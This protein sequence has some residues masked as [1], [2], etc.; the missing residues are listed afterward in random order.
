[1]STDL[2]VCLLLPSHW[3]AVTGGAEMQAALL[4]NRLSKLGRFDVHYVARRSAPDYVPEGY[5]LHRLKAR[6]MVAGTLVLELPELLRVLK[7]LQPDVIYQRVACA[8]TGAAAW[9]ARTQHRR[10]VWHV[11]S[12]RDLTP[13]PWKLSWR[14]PLEQ[15]SKLMVAYGARCA[16]TVIVQNAAQA[17]FL[18]RYHGR[19]DAVHIPNFH[20]APAFPVK[21]VAQR[22]TVC[23]VS[24]VKELKQPE[25]FLRLAADF[26]PRAG[27]E[28]VMVGQPQM[29][30]KKW[31]KVEAA[32]RTLPNL[33]F[34]GLIT[35]SAVEELL[36]RAHVLVNTST[37]EGFPNAFIQAW[38]REV[39]VLSLNV[40]PD[41]LLDE[42]RCGFCAHG[43]YEAM[44]SWLERAVADVN[45]RERIG[46]RSARYARERFSMSNLD[47]LARVIIQS[48]AFV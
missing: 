10:L 21:K 43:S 11:S 24:N 2:R 42:E 28:F 6:P 20:V 38:L 26:A 9:F 3:S 47:A 39:P 45:L 44:R 14:A 18:R 22:V 1:M 46:Q 41:G 34:L 5:T 36:E 29:R 19:S 48:A 4:A 23:W 7:Y 13:L 12:D 15:V 30:Q 8:Y 35:M 37:V 31:Q 33:R 40:N 17:E 25:V 32:I 27:V 16:D